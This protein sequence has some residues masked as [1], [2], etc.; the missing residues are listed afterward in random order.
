M[1]VLSQGFLVKGTK[2]KVQISN[3]VC[4]APAKA[5]LLNFKGHNSYFG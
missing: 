3:I 5:F 4:D 1:I 2:F